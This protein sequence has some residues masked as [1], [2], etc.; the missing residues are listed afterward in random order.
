MIDTQRLRPAQETDQT[1]PPSPHP[2]GLPAAAANR[3]LLAFLTGQYFSL[4]SLCPDHKPILKLMARET[5]YKSIRRRRSE[6][7]APKGAGAKCELI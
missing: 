7:A 2:P 6:P 3:S 4:T 5:I 1:D